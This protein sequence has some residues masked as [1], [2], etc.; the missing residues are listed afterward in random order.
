MLL[1]I[2]LPPLEHNLRQMLE[3]V[4]VNQIVQPQ[5]LN[6]LAPTLRAMGLAKSN[7]SQVP[8][9]HLNQP[10][11]HSVITSRTCLA[12][13]PS[14][15]HLSELVELQLLLELQD[16]MPGVALQVS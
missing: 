6:L 8:L 13:P 9:L 16:L 11:L 7:H 14:H 2:T 10:I 15:Q 3:L 12:I 4:P 1:R 5:V